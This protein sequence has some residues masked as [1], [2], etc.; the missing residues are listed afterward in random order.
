MVD[1]LNSVDKRFI[2]ELMPNILLTGSIR[3]DSQM[4]MYTGK[5]IYDVSSAEEFQQHLSEYHYQKWCH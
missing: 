3:L 5:Q 2:Y 4:K 1:E